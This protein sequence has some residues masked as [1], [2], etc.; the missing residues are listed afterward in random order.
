MR[1]PPSPTVGEG[2]HALPARVDGKRGCARKNGARAAPA[3]SDTWGGGREAG[4]PWVTRVLLVTLAIR[5]NVSPAIPQRRGVEDAAPYGSC[6]TYAAAC[7]VTCAV[8][9]RRTKGA[10]A[11]PAGLDALGGG[12]EAG[13]PWITWMLS[14]TPDG[15]NQ[16]GPAIPRSRGVEDAAPYGRLRNERLSMERNG[17]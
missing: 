2:F 8:L 3:G 7:K 13:A 4:A 15:C 5:A 12:R 9:P 16:P 10:R 14:D 11:V 6:E 17:H 1:I